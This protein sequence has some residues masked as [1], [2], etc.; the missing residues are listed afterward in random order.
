MPKKKAITWVKSKWF[1]PAC[2]KQD[3]WQDADSGDD[4]YHDFVVEC[5]SCKHVMCCVEKVEVAAA[6][7]PEGT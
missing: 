2:G 3:M 6:V 7:L 5:H 1:C 4:Y